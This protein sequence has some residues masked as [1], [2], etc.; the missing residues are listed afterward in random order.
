MIFNCNISKKKLPA[1]RRFFYTMN[2]MKIKLLCFFVSLFTIAA[3]SQTYHPD[4]IT[5]DGKTYDY[6]YHHMEQYFRSFPDKR[7]VPNKDSTLLNRGYIAE[8]E[9]DQTRTFYLKD[10]KI[11]QDNDF[12]RLISTMDKVSAQENEKMPL[13]WVNGLFDIGIGNPI[14]GKDSLSPSYTQYLVIE[15]TKGKLTRSNEFTEKQLKSFKS[16]Q[17]NTFYYSAAYRRTYDLLKRSGMPEDEI[18]DHI[19]YHILFYSKRNFLI[20]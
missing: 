6:R 18:E 5:I 17:W 9:I 14:Y 15:I 3:I 2:C 4:K 19:Y 20:K 12:N 1:F 13:F 10:I 8:F 11:P 16:Y 7:P